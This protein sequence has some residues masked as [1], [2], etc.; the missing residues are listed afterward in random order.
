MSLCRWEI[1]TRNKASPSDGVHRNKAA[2]V[3]VTQHIPTIFRRAIKT[4]VVRDTVGFQPC[5]FEA[6]GSPGDEDSLDTDNMIR[7]VGHVSLIHEL[8]DLS[9]GVLSRLWVFQEIRLSDVIQFV[10]CP[11]SKTK[12]VVP[13]ISFELDYLVY[14]SGFYRNLWM[15]TTSWIWYGRE[16]PYYEEWPKDNLGFIKAFCDT[17]TVTSRPPQPN[18]FPMYPGKRYFQHQLQSTRCTSKASD[19]I[20]AIMPQYGF[21]T[22]PSDAKSM[23]FTQLFLNCCDQLS[24]YPDLVPLIHFGAQTLCDSFSLSCPVK[25]IVEPILSVG[26]CTFTFRPYHSC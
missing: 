7:F 12:R 6:I 18:L 1:R 2:R 23:T 20:L 24:G 14:V 8:D 9:D 16:P 5:C 26:F 3:A 10:R 4:V 15:M 13:P 22:I 21:Y 17:T 25:T 19:F 11:R